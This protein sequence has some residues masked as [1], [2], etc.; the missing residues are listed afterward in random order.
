[1]EG[2]EVVREVWEVGGERLVCCQIILNS[3]FDHIVQEVHVYMEHH[4]IK[5]PQI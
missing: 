3:A 4:Y 1:M 2:G 5:R